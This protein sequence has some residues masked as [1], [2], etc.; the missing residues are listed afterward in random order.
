M[1]DAISVFDAVEQSRSEGEKTRTG[2]DHVFVSADQGDDAGRSDED[3]NLDH[4]EWQ[5][6]DTGASGRGVVDCLESDGEVVHFEHEDSKE[7]EQEERSA[8]AG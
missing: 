5:K 7:V 8:A 6:T 1:R 3:D 2:D 4:D